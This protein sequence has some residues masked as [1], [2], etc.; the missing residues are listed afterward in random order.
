MRTMNQM[1]D[2]LSCILIRAI[3]TEFQEVF[4]GKNLFVILILIQ[5]V[6]L[7]TE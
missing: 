2:T 6:N 3:T 7:F 1:H 4:T 5:M